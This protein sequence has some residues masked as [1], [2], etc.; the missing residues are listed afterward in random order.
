MRRREVLKASAAV[1]GA[2]LAR[3][4]PAR[5]GDDTT[6]T[7]ARA[8]AAS[9]AGSPVPAGAGSSLPPLFEKTPWDRRGLWEASWVG[10]ADAGRAAARDGVP[11]ALRLAGRRER[12]PARERR[13]A[14]RAVPRRPP[15]RPRSAS[16]ARPS[17]GSTTTRRRRRWPPGAHVLVARVFSL[18]PHA[19]LAQFQVRPAFLLA[20]EGPEA[21]RLDTGVAPWEG[22]APAR[23]LGRAAGLRLG[24]RR[25]GD[26]RRRGFAWGFERGEGEG[27]RPVVAHERAS[28]ALARV[29][30]RARAL[31]P[32]RD[33]AA[34]DRP[35]LDA[36]P[37]APRGRRR[38]RST[39]CASRFAPAD[40]LASEAGRWQELLR[41]PRARAGAGAHAPPRDRR[42]R[43]LRVRLPCARHLGREGERRPPAVRR[44]P[45]RSSR[46]SG[47]S[48]RATATSS[49]ASSS[50]AWATA[51]CPT[52]ASSRRFEALWFASGRY[53]RDRRRDGRASR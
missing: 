52:A 31:P 38:P 9:A 3:V 25:A 2:A 6:A 8:H 45:A 11:A 47:S 27:W 1:V 17:T 13:R 42:P 44:G 26:G 40:H 50:S 24:P 53:L 19:P 5:A 37:R 28:S 46:T 15:D 18:G 30:H 39:R 10:C 36:R 48:R 35:P 21:K 29:R 51:S 14:L 4:T 32:G 49:K 43:G 33:A 16:A 22:T 41:R 34:D 20:A 12:A 23:L 7:V